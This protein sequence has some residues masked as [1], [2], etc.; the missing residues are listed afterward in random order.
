M[1][2]NEKNWN[3]WEVAGLF[4]VLIFGNLLHFLYD[5]SGQ[6]RIA[7]IFAPVN[8]SVWEHIRLFLVPWL[9]WSLAEWWGLRGGKLPV[10]SSRLLGL[11]AGGLF[12]PV[13]YYAYHGA[14]GCDKPVVNIIIFQLAVLLGFLI[15]RTAMKKRWLDGTGWQILCGILLAAVGMLAVLWTMEPPSAPVFVDP[16]TG[17]RGIPD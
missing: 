3:S 15:S 5:W 16:T 7:A 12:I 4:L 2:R 9:L 1:A 13:C 14:L 11:L 10:L 6:S 8:E 17:K